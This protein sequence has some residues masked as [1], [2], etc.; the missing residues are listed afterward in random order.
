VPLQLDLDDYER[1]LLNRIL[2]DHL[3][4]LRMEIGATDNRDMRAEMHRAEDAIKSILQR[5]STGNAA[6]TA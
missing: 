3:G 6:R 2:E 1:D 5:I 4:N